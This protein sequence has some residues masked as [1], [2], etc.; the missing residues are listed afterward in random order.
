MSSNP[1]PTPTPA[2][3]SSVDPVEFGALIERMRPRLRP[4]LARHRIPPQDSEDLL[5]EV[6]LAA[7]RKWHTIAAPESWLLGVL[8]LQCALYWRR[9][10]SN[11][12]QSVEST[13]L[14]ELSTPLPPGQEGAEWRWDVER[15]TGVLEARHR[16][17]L[18]LRF[19]LGLSSQEI[20][21]RLGY[22]AAGVRKLTY[23]CLAK[24]QR[25]AAEAGSFNSRA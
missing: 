23:R 8:R 19:G 5:Q 2:P 6:F 12:V 13:L 14:E 22:S 17:A 25:W 9:C 18:W 16:S 21:T 7:Y 20:A 11:R 10:R 15:L 4:V 1:N 3:E 24:V